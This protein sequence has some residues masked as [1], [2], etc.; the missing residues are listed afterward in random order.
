V[1]LDRYDALSHLVDHLRSS[2][3]QAEGDA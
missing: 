1:R 3:R 2:R